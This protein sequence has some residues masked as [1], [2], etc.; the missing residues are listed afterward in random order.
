MRLLAALV[1][2]VNDDNQYDDNDD[3]QNADAQNRDSKGAV[4]FGHFNFG[5]LKL[6]FFGR[7]AARNY[8][9]QFVLLFFKELDAFVD[10]VPLAGL[11]VCV[12]LALGGQSL[13]LVLKES[14]YDCENSLAGGLRV[15]F[16]LQN[17][18]VKS[19]GVDAASVGGSLLLQAF[20]IF[21]I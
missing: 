14:L 1:V 17:V 15:Q 7:N 11:A 20:D 10:L 19:L 8:V 3:K 13:K 5:K 9:E 4:Q 21:K 2:F 16:K 12:L 6:D 18:F